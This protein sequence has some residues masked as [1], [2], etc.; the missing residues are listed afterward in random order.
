MNGPDLKVLAGNASNGARSLVPAVDRAIRILTL[1]EAQPNQPM[2]V[3]DIARALD[4]PKS[5]TFNI[6]SALVEGQLLRRSRDG[7]QLGRLLVQ[8]GS[9]YVSSINLVRE[10]YE[11][12][13]TAPADLQA[14]IQLGVL[15]E[16][17]NVIFL[18]YQDCDSGLRLGLGGAVGRLVPANCSACGKALLA[19][20]PEEE[21]R[22]R[23]A[24]VPQLTKLTRHSISSPARLAKE[25]ADIRRDGYST[26]DEETLADLRCV[27]M[28]FP[29]SYA[30][31]GLV[32][33]SISADKN[34]LTKKRQNVIRDV[35]RDVVE[36]LQRRV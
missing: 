14:T 31:Y 22:Q 34:T 24:A 10:F 8:L 32:A 28:A 15:D 2:T 18:A 12:A 21:F 26:D 19:L 36:A 27:A 33:V 17:L 30:D 7:F 13:V 6:C 25:I 5:T 4:I 9:A 1:L 16:R 20:L 11:V 29:T 35:L 3:S 23:L